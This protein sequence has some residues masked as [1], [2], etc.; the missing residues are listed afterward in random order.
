MKIQNRVEPDCKTY[1][2]CGGCSLRH[3]DYITCKEEKVQKF[4]NKSLK[5]RVII[6]R[7]N[8]MDNIRYYRNRL[9][10]L[11]ALIMEIKILVFILLEL[12]K[13]VHFERMF[14]SIWNFTTNYRYIIDN[15]NG[16][17][18]MNKES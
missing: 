7:Y 9:F 4:D 16:T 5:N 10:I 18:M 1:K 15:Y 13:V 3:I 6:W 11:F 14:Y 17:I 2:T 8:R 12:I